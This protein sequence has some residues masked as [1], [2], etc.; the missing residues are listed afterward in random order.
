[1][2]TR[3]SRLFSLQRKWNKRKFRLFHLFQSASVLLKSA[4]ADG[5]A[6]V[7]TIMELSDSRR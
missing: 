2:L 6:R 3:V 1:M 4:T 5:E 7:G